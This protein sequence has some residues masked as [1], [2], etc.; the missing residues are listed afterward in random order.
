MAYFIVT[1]VIFFDPIRLIV[2]GLLLW[3]LSRG[4]VGG[5]RIV[6][7]SASFASSLVLNLAISHYM[8]FGG[9]NERR[10]VSAV[11]V[12]VL[13]VLVFELVSHL[14]SKKRQ[15]T[16]KVTLPPPPADTFE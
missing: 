4:L 3:L 9:L 2:N 14:S 16:E 11:L 15:R 10:F 1:L 13:Y 6:R 7:L 12:S 8:S 5:G